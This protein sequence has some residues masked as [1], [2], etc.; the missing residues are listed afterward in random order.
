MKIGLI[1][2]LSGYAPAIS[3]EYSRNVLEPEYRPSFAQVEEATSALP[4]A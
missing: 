3:V 2:H 4:P 1:A